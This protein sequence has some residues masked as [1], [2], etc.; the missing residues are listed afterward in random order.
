M[1]D[2]L[3][4][5]PASRSH[6]RCPAPLVSGIPAVV[7]TGSVTPLQLTVSSQTLAALNASVECTHGSL[8]IASFE[9]GLTAT[10][11]LYTAPTSPLPD[12]CTVAYSAGD[13]RYTYVLTSFALTPVLPSCWCRACRPRC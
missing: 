3:L 10:S 6:R 7:L 8:S 12:S 11:L 1:T 5:R 4:S 9:G 2:T 13:V